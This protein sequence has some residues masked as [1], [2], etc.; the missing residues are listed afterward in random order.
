MSVI[1]GT[2]D[3]ADDADIEIMSTE[4]KKTQA[5][6][7]D[8][9]VGDK[10]RETSDADWQLFIARRRAERGQID[11]DELRLTRAQRTELTAR[12]FERSSGKAWQE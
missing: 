9:P 2:K 6:A 10:T 5:L 3:L 1:I 7:R 8:Q 11:L 12:E 4:G